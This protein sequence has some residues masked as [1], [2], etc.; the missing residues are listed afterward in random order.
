METQKFEQ[1]EFIKALVLLRKDLVASQCLIGREQALFLIDS[2]DKIQKIRKSLQMQWKGMEKQ[3]KPAHMIKYIHKMLATLEAQLKIA[4]G[5]YSNQTP[6]G[7]WA[8]K[9]V[10][11]GPIIAAS[12]DALIDIKRAPYV[13]NIWSYAGL[14][15]DID[16]IYPEKASKIVNEK[17]KGATATEDEMIELAKVTR[18]NVY[19]CLDNLKKLIKAPNPLP[20]TKQNL[21][22]ALSLIPWNPKLK[23]LCFLIGKSFVHHS[24]N[25]SC[26][27]GKIYRE[28]RIQ[29]TLK[30]ERGEYRELA[31]RKVNTVGKDTKAYEAY[32]QGKLPDGH[33]V[34]IAMRKTVKVFLEHWFSAAYE[35]L[36]GKTAPEPYPIAILGHKDKIERQ[37]K[38]T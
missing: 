14:L 27:Y 24:N 34:S 33:I 31:L 16:R 38:I 21:I 1:K 28:F 25:E 7:K 10:G 5:H 13:G 19:R 8:R 18:R 11:I 9:I 22:K 23:R 35:L 30:S 4:I 17:V 26:Y 32:S 3:D 29:E 6:M 20:A 37:Q 2:Y 36:L 12:L 15:A